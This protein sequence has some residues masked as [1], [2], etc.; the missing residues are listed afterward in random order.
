MR[1]E[2]IDKNIIYVKITENRTYKTKITRERER[3]RER[4]RDEL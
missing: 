1:K 2:V 3:E 4:E